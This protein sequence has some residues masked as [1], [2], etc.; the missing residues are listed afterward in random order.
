MSLIYNVPLAGSSA[1]AT[2]TP[3]TVRYAYATI[4]ASTTDGTFTK[5][6]GA[7]LAGS[8]G[9]IIRVLGVLVVAG[10]TATTVRFNSKGSGA[11][12]AISP[13]F[14]VGANGG[15]SVPATAIGMMK[16][17]SGEN[18]TANVGGA[19]A[20]IMLSYVLEPV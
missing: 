7:G 13:D 6:D 19:T 18:L 11:G 12:T 8:V 3:L 10:S 2:A 17:A 1:T 5:D 9:F 20:Y 14:P 15:F 16:T 4:N